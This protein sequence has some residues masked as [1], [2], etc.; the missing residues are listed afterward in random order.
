ML[1]LMERIFPNGKW[2]FAKSSFFDKNFINSEIVIK[3]I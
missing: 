3:L 1:A 2:S